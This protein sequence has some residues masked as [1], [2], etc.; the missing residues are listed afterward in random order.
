MKRVVPDRRRQAASAP[1]TPPKAPP[2][3]PQQPNPYEHQ[4]G[5]IQIGPTDV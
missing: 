5:R 3:A 4:D 2:P 1:Q